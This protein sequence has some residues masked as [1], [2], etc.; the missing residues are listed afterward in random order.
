M[1]DTPTL[2]ERGRFFQSGPAPVWAALAGEG[3]ELVASAHMD[4]IGA[5]LDD[6]VEGGFRPTQVGADDLPA[7]FVEH[8]WRL[9]DEAAAWI[10][11]D[12][13]ARSLVQVCAADVLGAL[14]VLYR[15]RS[16]CAAGWGGPECGQAISADGAARLVAAAHMAGV[17]EMMLISARLGII[18]R[19]ALA[20]IRREQQAEHG[21]A[22]GE[23]RQNHNKA[24]A[25]AAWV[26]YKGGKS[27]T[28]WAAKH[29][30]DYGVSKST[31]LGWLAE[32]NVPGSS[33][34]DT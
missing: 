21:R 23:R 33:S 6:L 15:V 9:G 2:P 18:D 32:K 29:A 17:Q 10:A 31:L 8:F 1:S 30:G 11:A 4:T 12:P 16:E 24:K 5:A 26:A 13:D 27:K 34:L 3:A 20:D 28:A 25:R 14:A 7:R 22:S 19:A